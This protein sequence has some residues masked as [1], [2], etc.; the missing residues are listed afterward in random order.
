[1]T[2]HHAPVPFFPEVHEGLTKSWMAPF[3]PEAAC[4]PP[5]SSPPSMAGQLGLM[6]TLPRWRERLL[7]TCAPQNLLQEIYP[8]LLPAL[9]HIINT[10]H[11][12]GTFPRWRERLLCTCALTPS[13]RNLSHTFTSTHT[14]HQHISPHRHLPHR[15][16]A[17]PG[18]STAQKTYLKHF[19]FR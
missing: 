16:Q 7:C 5:P 12:T 9:T 10:S 2:H 3:W 11:L 18:N 6:W 8:T 19:T 17:G 1:M 4:L 15:I 14:H 13:P